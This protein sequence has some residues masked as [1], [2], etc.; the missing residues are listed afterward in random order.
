MIPDFS[1]AS[2]FTEIRG[3]LIQAARSIMM[4][5]E[6][7]YRDIA[8]PIARLLKPKRETGTFTVIRTVISVLP[9]ILELISPRGPEMNS[10]TTL[11]TP[12]CS[13]AN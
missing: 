5:H 10:L 3:I 12:V 6:L 7:V 4:D 13:S 8:P 1:K 2:D 11:H 9:S